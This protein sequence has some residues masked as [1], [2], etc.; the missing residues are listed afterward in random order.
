MCQHYSRHY[1]EVAA[2]CARLPKSECFGCFEN[3]PSP[4][5]KRP[6]TRKRNSEA[7]E[8]VTGPL[9]EVSKRHRCPQWSTFRS[10]LDPRASIP[11]CFSIPGPAEC[12]KRLNKSRKQVDMQQSPPRTGGNTY[13]RARGQVQN[14]NTQK[15]QN[16][17]TN[18]QNTHKKT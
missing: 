18:T 6:F 7:L 17:R 12:A 8:V 2:C 11:T 4:V 3:C 13:Q 5:A 1:L 15:T 10:F 14:K 9:P 16:K